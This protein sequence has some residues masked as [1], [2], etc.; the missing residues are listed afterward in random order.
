MSVHSVD[1]MGPPDIDDGYRGYDIDEEGQVVEFYDHT[2]ESSVHGGNSGISGSK[3]LLADPPPAQNIAATRKRAVRKSA[4]CCSSCVGCLITIGK[5]P[6]ASAICMILMWVGTGMFIGGGWAVLDETQALYQRYGPTNGNPA[7]DPPPEYFLV[8]GG[9]SSLDNRYELRNPE[10]LGNRVPEVF[11][12]IKRSFC[13]IIAFM[14]VFSIIVVVD[15]SRSTHEIHSSTRGCKSS[16]AGVCCSVSIIFL[17]Y[18]LLLG[19]VFW[20]CFATLGVYYYRVVMLRCDDMEHRGFS[21][22]VKKDICLDLVQFGIVMFKNTNDQDFGKICGPGDSSRRTVGQLQDY[23]DNYSHAWQ[24]M[25][26]CFS[27]ALL[28]IIAMMHSLMIVTGN[29]NNLQRRYM[30][31]RQSRAQTV[32]SYSPAM[33]HRTA[34]SSNATAPPFVVGTRNGSNGEYRRRRSKDIEMD[35]FDDDGRMPTYNEA[36]G[37][38]SASYIP[39]QRFQKDSHVGVDYYYKRY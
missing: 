19:W 23:C 37:T 24:L 20:L 2:N 11:L 15:G 28:N 35:H 25:L 32:A 8:G 18:G 16:S 21:E 6:I 22:G 12:G 34:V 26:V 39:P 27:G 4:G 17:S 7:R 29:Y 10:D 31:P 30:R 38:P 5:L 36:V 33:T 13:G 9:Q 3:R 14:F 1:H